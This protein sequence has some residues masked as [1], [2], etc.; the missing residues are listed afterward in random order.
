MTN[1]SYFSVFCERI[2]SFFRNISP[3]K[4]NN[5]F[6]STKYSKYGSTVN[7]FDNT[8]LGEAALED[9]GN[10]NMM[11]RDLQTALERSGQEQAKLEIKLE[12]LSTR[13]LELE[14]KLMQTKVD[15]R[16]AKMSKELHSALLRSEMERKTLESKLQ[17]IQALHDEELKTLFET[18]KELEDELARHKS[19]M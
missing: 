5:L 2:R 8:E 1:K 14:A 9:E 16:E 17:H 7:F 15:P 10:N 3:G 11:V 4:K 19:N 13:I 6:P 12:T 18:I